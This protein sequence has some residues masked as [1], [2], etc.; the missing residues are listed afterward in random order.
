MSAI[1][2]LKLMT[3]CY[4]P[5]WRVIYM[6]REVIRLANQD[7]DLLVLQ[8]GIFENAEM[9]L[10]RISWS[11]E[12]LCT[13]RVPVRLQGYTPRLLLRHPSIK[14]PKLIAK[15]FKGHSLSLRTSPK[16]PP[17]SLMLFCQRRA[18]RKTY[19]TSE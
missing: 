19:E 11:V 18:L 2:L 3:K 17:V 7:A 13:L 9:D 16:S 4:L 14:L 8:Q 10:R 15:P 12:S 1:L 5:T 6:E